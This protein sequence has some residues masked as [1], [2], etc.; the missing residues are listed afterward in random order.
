MRSGR[1]SALPFM[2]SGPLGPDRSRLRTTRSLPIYYRLAPRRKKGGLL[3][4]AGGKGSQPGSGG[5]LAREASFGQVGR[6][7]RVSPLLSVQPV[8]EIGFS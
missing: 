3:Y 5:F 6:R 1:R 4:H 8:F 2:V 7:L